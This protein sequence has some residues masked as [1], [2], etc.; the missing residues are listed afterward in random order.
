MLIGWLI[1]GVGMLS[2][3]FVFHVLARRKPH[4][5]SGVYAYA[6]VGLGDYVGFSS[7]WGYWLGSVIAQVWLRN[8]IFLHVGPLRTAVFPRSS[9]CVS[10]G[11]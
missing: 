8:V 6:R 11:S 7:A 4:L 9:I 10:V 5:D 1:A 2:V 3:A